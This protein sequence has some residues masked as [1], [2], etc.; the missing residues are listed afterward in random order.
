[1]KSVPHFLKG[2][3]RNAMR[4]SMEEATHVNVVRSE[5]EWRLFMLL[6]RLSLHRPSR[7]GHIHK[8]KLAERLNDFAE[9][10]WTQL[11]R[12]SKKCDEEA[13]AGMQRKRRR[14]TQANELPQ[15]CS[16]GEL[17]GEALSGASI[18]PG[19]QDTLNSVRDREETTSRES[20]NS[21]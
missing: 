13:P 5:R 12:A 3:Y 15:S 16:D 9:G 6:P 14:A 21:S 2:P 8:S 17:L 1:M 7:R 11:L 4:L 20:S 10:K 19:N 18:A